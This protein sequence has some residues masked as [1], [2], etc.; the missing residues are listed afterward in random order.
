MRARDEGLIA[1]WTVQTADPRASTVAAVLRSLSITR[2]QTEEFRLSLHYGLVDLRIT[3]TGEEAPSGP[4]VIRAVQLDRLASTT[5]K[6]DNI[7]ARLS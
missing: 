7:L 4:E 2:R 5:T 1:Y 3:P 6:L